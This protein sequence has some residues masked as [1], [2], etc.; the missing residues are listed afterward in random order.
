MVL[1]R[2][3]H[4]S[5]GEDT[6]LFLGTGTEFDRLGVRLLGLLPVGLHVGGNGGF[7]GSLGGGVTHGD[8]F[9]ERSDRSFLTAGSETRQ[10]RRFLLVVAGG[11]FDFVQ[12][13]LRFVRG[14]GSLGPFERFGE[15]EVRLRQFHRDSLIAVRLF[16]LLVPSQPVA[17]VGHKFIVFLVASQQHQPKPVDLIEH[18]G[19]LNLAIVFVRGPRRHHL[20][21]DIQRGD[22]IS[23]F[24]ACFALPHLRVNAGSLFVV[25]LKD[26]VEFIGRLLEHGF[27][28]RIGRFGIG[29]ANVVIDGR[30]LE[31][32]VVPRIHQRQVLAFG[33]VTGELLLAAL[34]RV[35]L[36]DACLVH[37]HRFLELRPTLGE[38]LA[39]FRDQ[40][41][42][43]R[44]VSQRRLQRVL[45]AEQRDVAGGH[46][47]R[48]RLFMVGVLC[49]ELVE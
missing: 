9:I 21:V 13:S 6:V 45:S 33:T 38:Q 4:Q 3:E 40:G 28:V 11:L 19:P 25:L 5:S 15:F 1:R 22:E 31:S 8:G 30:H 41:V 36:V 42:L 44:L 7:T 12:P 35:N 14:L 26:F 43:L 17:R 29:Q 16:D 46:L 32:R 27:A 18:R 23:H 24:L 20:V 49:Q 2:R 47:S 39:S 34:G 10:K 48:R 37:R